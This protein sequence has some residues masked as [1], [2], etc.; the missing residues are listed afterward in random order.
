MKWT[1]LTH[2]QTEAQASGVIARDTQAPGRWS[3]LN[4]TGGCPTL[5]RLLSETVGHS[6]LRSLLES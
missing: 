6:S 4:L 1:I 2:G 5:S 3:T